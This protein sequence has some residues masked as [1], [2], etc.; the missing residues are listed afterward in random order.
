MH[1]SP[2]ALR[3]LALQISAN[4]RKALGGEGDQ[5]IDAAGQDGLSS[6]SLKL[7]ERGPRLEAACSALADHLKP[8]QLVGI[9]FLLLL[10]RQQVGGAILADEM[11][12][13]KTAQAICFLGLLSEFE[14]DM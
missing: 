4:L 9:N 6:N 3:S 11:G 7:V 1:N 10:Y 12:L 2:T 5:I 14:N 13:G 8:Y